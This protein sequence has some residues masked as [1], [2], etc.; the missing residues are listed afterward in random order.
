MATRDKPT[1]PYEVEI[2]LMQGPTILAG[3]VKGKVMGGIVTFRGADPLIPV[4]WL[5]GEEW[6]LLNITTKKRVLYYDT[7]NHLLMKPNSL[8]INS[9]GVDMMA[10]VSKS[11]LLGAREAEHKM[12]IETNKDRTYLMALA[13]MLFIFIIVALVLYLIAQTAGPEISHNAVTTVIQTAN[14]SSGLIGHGVV[15]LGSGSS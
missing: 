15:P 4:V 5:G 9:Q 12:G 14:S 7:L 13:G 6:T 1:R 11:F 10:S 2:Q 3:K 8:G